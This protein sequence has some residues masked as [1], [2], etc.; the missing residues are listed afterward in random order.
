LE[1][2]ADRL[3]DFLEGIM[4]DGWK[5]RAGKKLDSFMP[6]NLDDGEEVTWLMICD[7]YESL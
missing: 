7:D 3:S 2:V 5:E 1:K 4:V 6:M